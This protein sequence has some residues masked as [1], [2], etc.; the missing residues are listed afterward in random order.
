MLNWMKKRL[1]EIGIVAILVF[2]GAT[3]DFYIKYS[4]AEE[5]N[6]KKIE[7]Q[8]LMIKDNKK[9]VEQVKEEYSKLNNK[10]SKSDEISREEHK[11]LNKNM[12]KLVQSFERFRFVIVKNND[13]VKKDLEELKDLSIFAV[14]DTTFVDDMA[15]Y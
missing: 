1:K 15:F 6:Q 2:F 8:E 12:G 14:V 7:Y 3:I 11:I 5:V 10:L 9:I 13:G 4:V